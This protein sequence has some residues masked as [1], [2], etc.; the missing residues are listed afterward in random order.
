MLDFAYMTTELAPGETMREARIRLNPRKHKRSKRRVACYVLAASL[1]VAGCAGSQ[2]P[3]HA[4]PKRAPKSVPPVHRV[5]TVQQHPRYQQ[6]P[7]LYVA[8]ILQGGH[9]SSPIAT[10]CAYHTSKIIVA[11]YHSGIRLPSAW[12]KAHDTMVFGHRPITF[13]GLTFRNRGSRPIFT[14]VVC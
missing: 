1:A 12:N 14:L 13:D 3:T 6:D 7:H 11:D 10:E 4:T 8:A 9:E 5:T 2:T